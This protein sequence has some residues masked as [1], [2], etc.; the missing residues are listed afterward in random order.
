MVHVKVTL[1]VKVVADCTCHIVTVDLRWLLMICIGAPVDIILVHTHTWHYTTRCLI[2]AESAH[3]IPDAAAHIFRT[4]RGL[5]FAKLRQAHY[6]I[7]ICSCFWFRFEVHGHLGVDWCGV[8]AAGHRVRQSTAKMTPM[9]PV[10]NHR[11]AEPGLFQLLFIIFRWRGVV[12]H[13]R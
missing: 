9:R 11:Q 6:L 10:R 3:L 1:H 2:R 7:G 13:S 4:I 12:D 8:L 5:Y